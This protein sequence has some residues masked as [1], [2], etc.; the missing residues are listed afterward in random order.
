MDYLTDHNRACISQPFALKFH[1]T[2][3]DHL[4]LRLCN[5]ELAP[6]W[7]L[8]K[9]PNHCPELECGAIQVEDHLRENIAFEGVHPEGKGAGPVIVV[10]QGIWQPLPEYA[11]ITASLR[12]GRIKFTFAGT[13]LR[14]MWSLT[15][16]KSCFR[17]QNPLWILRKEPDIYALR[18]N[19][20]KPIDWMK[21]RSCRTRLTIEE[22]ERD[23]YLGKRRFRAGGSLFAL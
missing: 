15:R 1:R 10:D 2:Q 18:R 8:Y 21:L 12:N 3:K 20:V 23:W 17:P 4:D 19:Q 13:L 22:M 5:H 11:D 6:S 7:A 14:G 9:M 16:Q